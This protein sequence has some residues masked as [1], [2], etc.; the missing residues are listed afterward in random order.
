MGLSIYINLGMGLLNILTKLGSNCI[1]YGFHIAILM[2]DFRSR[3]IN[4]PILVRLFLAEL[5]INLLIEI[6]IG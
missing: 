5:N 1:L 2:F 3:I 6:C 4:L